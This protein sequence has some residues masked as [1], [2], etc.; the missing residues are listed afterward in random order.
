MEEGISDIQLLLFKEDSSTHV[1]IRLL[2]FG[3]A[4]Y[5]YIPRDRSP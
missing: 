1:H 2:L 4:C 3:F 5:R